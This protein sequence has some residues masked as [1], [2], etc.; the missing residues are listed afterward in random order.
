MSTGKRIGAV[1]LVLASV[2]LMGPTCGIK[3]RP[4]SPILPDRFVIYGDSISVDLHCATGV[5]REASVFARP[6]EASARTAS[7]LVASL[8]AMG[9]SAMGIDA[10]F[11]LSG[12]N[13]AIHNLTPRIGAILD[14]LAASTLN[15]VVGIPPPVYPPR[16]RDARPIGSTPPQAAPEEKT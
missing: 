9:E 1:I 14:A 11:V 2:F 15:V 5:C 16:L 10:V 3:G 7:K 6:G 8:G 13:D 12:T 4:R